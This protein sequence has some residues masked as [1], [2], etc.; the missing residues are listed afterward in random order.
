MAVASTALGSPLLRVH[1]G[2]R[3]GDIL[4]GMESAHGLGRGTSHS[5]AGAPTAEDAH[6]AVGDAATSVSFTLG[7]TRG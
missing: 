3:V 6:V 4:G 1:A 5:F 2:T 7:G